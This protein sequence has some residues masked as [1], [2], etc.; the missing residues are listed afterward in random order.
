MKSIKTKLDYDVLFVGDNWE[1]SRGFLHH[2]NGSLKCLVDANVYTEGEVFLIKPYTKNPF[3]K[4]IFK[5]FNV[6]V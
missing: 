6:V 5:V 4:F 3:K 1:I 2:Q